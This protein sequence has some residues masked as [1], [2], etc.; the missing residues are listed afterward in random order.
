MRVNEDIVAQQGNNAKLKADNDLLFIEIDDLNK[1]QEPLALEEHVRNEL[2][3]IKPGKTF[4]RL[5]SDQYKCYV[6]SLRRP[7]YKIAHESS[8]DNLAIGHCCP[9]RA[10]GIGSHMQADCPKQYLTIGHRRILEHVINV[11]LRHP[12]IQ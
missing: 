1:S 11:L 7:T 10:I 5:V 4:Y 3:M 12:R 6:V 8:R 9:A 2:S